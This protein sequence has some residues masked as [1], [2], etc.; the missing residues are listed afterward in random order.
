MPLVVIGVPLSVRMLG[1]VAATLVTVPV[2]L[3]AIVRLPPAPPSVS[4][5]PVPAVS[6]RSFVSVALVPRTTYEA[7]VGAPPPPVVIVTTPTACV[8]SVTVPVGS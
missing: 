8:V 3:D 5:M 7:F 4:V 2:T 1:T 6:T